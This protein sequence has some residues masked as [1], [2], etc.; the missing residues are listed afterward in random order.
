MAYYDSGNFTNSI[1]PVTRN[2]LIINGII[3]LIGGLFRQTWLAGILGL[4]SID[5]GGFR[6]YQ[7]ITYMFT[8]VQFEHFFFNMFAVFMFGRSLE[9]YW[10]SKRFLIYYIV[11]GI[12]AGLIQVLICYL[13]SVLSITIGASGSVFGLLL[14]FG[15]IF[16]NIPIYIMLIPVPIKAKY[17]VIGYG[18]L[19]FFFG[20]ANRAGDNVAHFAHLGGMLFGIFMILYWKKKGIDHGNG[21]F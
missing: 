3:W 11:T 12:G 7:L 19:E 8:H 10:G 9:Y 6:A 16:P 14:A 21:F 5:G 18:V 13:Q 2:L 17:M 4:Q 1:P 15:M 20:I